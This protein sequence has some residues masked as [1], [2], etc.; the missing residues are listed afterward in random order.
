MVRVKVG[1]KVKRDQ[2]LF[3][4]KANNPALSAAAEKRL[5]NA[6]KISAGRVDPLPLFFGTIGG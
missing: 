6:V 5:K 3:E 1:Q 2:V 4:V